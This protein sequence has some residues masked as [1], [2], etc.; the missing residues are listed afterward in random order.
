LGNCQKIADSKK[1]VDAK[2]NFI[3]LGEISKKFTDAQDFC[4]KDVGSLRAKR[5]F[6]VHVRLE[7]LSR[8]LICST[9]AFVF[10]FS[11]VEK[12]HSQTYPDFQ[13]VDDLLDWYKLSIDQVEKNYACMGHAQIS[14]SSSPG[15]VVYDWFD[16]RLNQRT[17]PKN[18]YYSEVRR[19]YAGG[20]AAD[21]WEK[22]LVRADQ[23]YYSMG[24]FSQSLGLV[25]KPKA[26]AAG[27]P[28]KEEIS[29]HMVVPNLFMLALMNN[30]A[31]TAFRAETPF[32][33]SELGAL[34]LIEG[35]IESE[36]ANGFFV[37]KDFGLEIEFDKE[38]GWMPTKAKGY[39]R[40]LEKKGV[41]DR[42][43]FTMLQ[44][45]VETE[46]IKCNADEDDFVPKKVLWHKLTESPNTANLWKCRQFGFGASPMPRCSATTLWM[47]SAVRKDLSTT[48]SR[49][50]SNRKSESQT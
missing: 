3:K 18:L 41:V 6:E 5:Q 26:I 46:W 13:T 9:I 34:R 21:I 19:T 28:P 11:I 30:G 15:F 39:Y 20:E 29:R 7:S 17:D 49:S 14:G 43:H 32:L 16:V 36:S 42:S 45:Q 2:A 24:A 4:K 40:D 31:Y 8:Y 44:Y 12:A 48:S 47:P 37:N 35:K 23:K 33:L 22:Y 1:N 10:H 38:F 50:Y 27:Q 25:P